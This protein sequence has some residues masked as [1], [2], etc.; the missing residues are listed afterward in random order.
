MS[1]A[2]HHTASAGEL[3]QAYEKRLIETHTAQLREFIHE[4][5]HHLDY[6]GWGDSWER[7]CSEELRK[8]SDEWLAANP[9]PPAPPPNVHDLS[10]FAIPGVTA[11]DVLR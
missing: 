6:C 3:A 7:E 2:P 10:D 8:R 4:L 1:D 11:K 5:L 9:A